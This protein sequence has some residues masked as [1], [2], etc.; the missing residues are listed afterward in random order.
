MSRVR[1]IVGL[2]GAVVLATGMLALAGGAN[3]ASTRAVS[4]EEAGTV[5]GSAAATPCYLIANQASGCNV[6]NVCAAAGFWYTWGLQ[7][8]AGSYVRDT[9]YCNGVDATCSQYHDIGTCQRGP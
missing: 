5:Y 1:M 7:S 9:P 8:P 2:L 6:P 4:A 3:R